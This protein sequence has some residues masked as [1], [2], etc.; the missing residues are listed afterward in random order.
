MDKKE[1]LQKAME[2]FFRA[3]LAGYAGENKENVKVSVFGFKKTVIY[4][5]GE[6]TVIDEWTTTDHSDVSFGTTTILFEETP[7]WFMFYEGRYPKKVISFLKEAMTSQYKKGQFRGG[8]GPIR[9]SS[10]LF[11]YK[12]HAHKTGNLSFSQFSGHEKI[13]DAKT[14]KILGFHEYCGCS[15]L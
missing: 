9:W 1:I 8:R 10:D 13:S 12:N 7:I 4:T 5:E 6:F 3:L 11:V 14:G 2:V 15:M